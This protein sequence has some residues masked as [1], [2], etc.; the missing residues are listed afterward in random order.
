MNKVS[1]D[2]SEVDKL[3]LHGL[4]MNRNLAS[5]ENSQ[6]PARRHNKGRDSN[7]NSNVMDLQAN[8]TSGRR[9]EKTQ[10]EPYRSPPRSGDSYFFDELEAN[11]GTITTNNPRGN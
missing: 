9:L 10:E 3:H 5:T 11:L 4:N 6:S 7:M 2:L 8:I 1:K